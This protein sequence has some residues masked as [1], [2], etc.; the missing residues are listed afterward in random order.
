MSRRKSSDE[1]TLPQEGLNPSAAKLL[2]GSQVSVANGSTDS[3]WSH[4]LDM[5]HVQSGES[6]ATTQARKKGGLASRD[7]K[8]SPA[9]LAFRALE[10]MEV[11]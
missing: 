1:T 9:Y 8:A 3:G 5:S 4:S 7:Q 6:N 10:V 2:V 11:L